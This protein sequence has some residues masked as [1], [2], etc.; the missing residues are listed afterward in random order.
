[1]ISSNLK[2]KISATQQEKCWPWCGLYM[3]CNGNYPLK[4]YGSSSQCFLNSHKYCC[5]DDGDFIYCDTNDLLLS[6]GNCYVQT[7]DGKHCTNLQD[8]I[9]SIDTR[10]KCLRIYDQ[11]D[12]EGRSIAVQSG[13]YHNLVDY[14][15][16]A[17]SVSACFQRDKC[18]TQTHR[19]RS[20]N[21]KFINDFMIGFL[22]WLRRDRDNLQNG[23][24]QYFQIGPN[25]R[26]EVMEA[27]IHRRHL[28]TGTP[29][30]NSARE[31]TRNMNE[32]NTGDQAG[33]VLASRL[34]GSGR[35]L[36]NIF[37]QNPHMNMGHWRSIEND[38]YNLV[39]ASDEPVRFN[40]NLLYE[41]RSSTRPS[42]IVFRIQS[43]ISS[44]HDRIIEDIPNP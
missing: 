5:P 41:S 20:Y 31:F 32:G 4:R 38:V 8:E 3:R 36:R 24:V 25:G 13:K 16:T 30:D 18:E 17:R 14:V 6:E 33:H 28:D 2:F 43:N 35:D 42:S 1:M 40:I 10:G 44:V 15:I 29:P 39:A 11:S 22:P 26:T 19:K 21:C 9:K 27:L 7:V 37:P 23:P 12:C 34:G